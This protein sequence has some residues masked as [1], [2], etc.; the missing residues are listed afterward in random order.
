MPLFFF[1]TDDG[2]CFCDDDEGQDLPDAQTARRL[3]L[4]TLPS[5]ADDRLPD[6]DRRTFTICVRDAQGAP[7]Y[8]VEL[9]LRGEWQTASPI[10][11]AGEDRKG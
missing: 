6:G 8:A 2:D 5:L 3:A 10:R 11:A 9:A 4:A 1:D 7:V